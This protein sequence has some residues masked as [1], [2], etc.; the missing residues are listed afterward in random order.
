MKENEQASSLGYR[1]KEGHHEV[2]TLRNSQ[3]QPGITEGPQILVNTGDHTS[4]NTIGRK[5]AMHSSLRDQLSGHRQ[6]TTKGAGGEYG[7]RK[8]KDSTKGESS[9]PA[10]SGRN[11]LI[12]RKSS[13]EGAGQK[14]HQ[15]RRLHRLKPQVPRKNSNHLVAGRLQERSGLAGA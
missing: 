8:P 7:T 5:E 12:R 11:C 4:P 2:S 6:R 1:L 15:G 13:K 3:L 10:L 9:K 14:R